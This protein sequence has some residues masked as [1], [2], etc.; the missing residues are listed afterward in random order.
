MRCVFAHIRTSLQCITTCDGPCVIPSEVEESRCVLRET[1][2]LGKQ[3]ANNLKLDRK[4][5][6]IRIVL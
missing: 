2:D 3:F 6:K 1:Q 4:K 5:E